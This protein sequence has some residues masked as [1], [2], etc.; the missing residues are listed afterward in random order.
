MIILSPKVAQN[1]PRPEGF[2]DDEWEELFP[3]D[4]AGDEPMSA[5]PPT[6]EDDELDVAPSM[7]RDDEPEAFETERLEAEPEVEFP[8]VPPPPEAA[9]PNAGLDVRG[10][11]WRSMSGGD[12]LR[13]V[14]TSLAGLTTERTVH[15]D[16]VYWAGTGRHVMVAW[17]DMRND[18]RAFIVDRIRDAL[19]EGRD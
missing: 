12:P 4:K 11:I 1:E 3:Q 14:Y 8:E 7:S 17:D 13:I 16:Y 2:E 9:N 6:D 15:P 19:V 10:R 18:W 5:A